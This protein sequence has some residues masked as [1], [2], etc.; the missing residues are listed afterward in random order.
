MFGN[1][2][3]AISRCHSIRIWFGCALRIKH[4]S[5]TSIIRNGK[6]VVCA[7]NCCE[8]YANHIHADQTNNTTSN[9]NM[10]M[11]LKIPLFAS[12]LHDIHWTNIFI[13]LVTAASWFLL[14]LSSSSSFFFLRFVPFIIQWIKKRRIEINSTDL[15]NKS[16]SCYNVLHFLRWRIK[17][18]CHI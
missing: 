3:A 8:W 11:A 7:I 2:F 9:S 1:L 13:R 4:T 16:M 6:K 5:V 14:L 10:L 15:C 17:I 18:Y 12:H